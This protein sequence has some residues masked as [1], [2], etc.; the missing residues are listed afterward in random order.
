MSCKYE[1]C[2]TNYYFKIWLKLLVEF[3]FLHALEH[4]N[5]GWD[6]ISSMFHSH[7]KFKCESYCNNDSCA[8]TCMYGD[9]N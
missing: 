8:N 2:D 5:V 3:F 7:N 6:H 4:T 9:A 1:M